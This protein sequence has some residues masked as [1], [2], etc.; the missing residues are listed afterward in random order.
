MKTN[1]HI[2][3]FKTILKQNRDDIAEILFERKREKSYN[4]CTYFFLYSFSSNKLF[5]GEMEMIS[6]KRECLFDPLFNI[7]A[8]VK[9]A[10]GG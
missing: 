4:A 10:L 2:S 7:Y 5:K 1:E 8:V 3:I 9:R 6:V